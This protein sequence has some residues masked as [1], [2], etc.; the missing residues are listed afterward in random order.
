MNRI[1]SNSELNDSKG[2]SHIIH[3][4]SNRITSLRITITLL[5][6]YDMNTANFRYGIRL[7]GLHLEL[8]TNIIRNKN[9]K[10]LFDSKLKVTYF[11]LIFHK[12]AIAK[13]QLYQELSAF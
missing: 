4:T 7:H 13:F 5:L 6:L 12:S 2:I 9:N 3:L 11:K 1:D 10:V 8:P